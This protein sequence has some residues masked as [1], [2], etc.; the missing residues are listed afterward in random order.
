[1]LPYSL[2]VFDA[3][4]VT[5]NLPTHTVTEIALN[6]FCQF[7]HKSSRPTFN[8]EGCLVNSAATT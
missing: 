1:M 3:E 6:D 8:A 5:E 2:G 7:A 4:N